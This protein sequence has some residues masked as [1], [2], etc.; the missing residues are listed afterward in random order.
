[1]SSELV[2]DIRDFTTLFHVTFR[3]KSSEWLKLSVE[4]DLMDVRF[5]IWS[6]GVSLSRFCFLQRIFLVLIFVI[7]GNEILI[8][9]IRYSLIS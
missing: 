6:L 8:F 7:L 2:T 5:A 4:S 9:V 1:M 3:C